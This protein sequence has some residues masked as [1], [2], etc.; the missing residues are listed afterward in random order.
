VEPQKMEIKKAVLL[1]VN[2]KLLSSK[3]NSAYPFF[4]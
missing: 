2:V 4:A 3:L 1:T